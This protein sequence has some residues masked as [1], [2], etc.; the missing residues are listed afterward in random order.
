[1][2]TKGC[3]FESFQGSSFHMGSQF[4]LIVICVQMTSPPSFWHHHFKFDEVICCLIVSGTIYWTHNVIVL[5]LMLCFPRL[6]TSLVSYASFLDVPFVIYYLVFLSGYP[7]MKNSCSSAVSALG[8]YTKGC[9]FESFQGSSFHMGS[10]FWL[11]VICVQMIS[12]HSFWHH[13]FKFDEVICC[14]IVSGIIYWTH[15]LIVL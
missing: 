6:Y 3:G 4:W 13:H 5:Y 11:I 2:Y 8:M 10:Q 15:N 14:S 1:M 7:H 9:G 12:P